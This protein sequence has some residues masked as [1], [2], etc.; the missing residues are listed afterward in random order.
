MTLPIA[1]LNID[2]TTKLA[3]APRKTVIRGCLVAMIAAMRKVLSPV[4]VRHAF[5]A[6]RQ[7]IWP[8][9]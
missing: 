7:S 3:K 8:F 1:A 9:R 2:M 4:R 5:Q 6:I